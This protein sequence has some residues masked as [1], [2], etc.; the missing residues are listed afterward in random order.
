MLSRLD[1]TVT[2][3]STPI[4]TAFAMVSYSVAFEGFTTVAHHLMLGS[5]SHC[6]D[7]HFVVGTCSFGYSYFLLAT[8]SQ[9]NFVK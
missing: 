3:H 4:T 6:T 9:I 5:R 1:Y 2:T 7:V 8:V